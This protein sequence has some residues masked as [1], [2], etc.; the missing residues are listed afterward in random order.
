MAAAAASR[1]RAH[2]SEAL[3]RSVRAAAVWVPRGDWAAVVHGVKREFRVPQLSKIKAPRPVVLYS[4]SDTGDVDT[5]MAV[6]EDTWQEPLG[7]ITQRSL[8]A[9]GF[10]A[11]AEFRG[12][13]R[14]RHPKQGFRPLTRVQVFAP[15]PWTP[16][17][18]VDQARWLLRELYGPF[19]GDG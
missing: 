14:R 4:I 16:D 17:D 3:R 5:A 8:L 2:P 11:Y 9:E 15:R 7:A 19:L 13:W 1:P 18:D 12:Y 6:L 10:R